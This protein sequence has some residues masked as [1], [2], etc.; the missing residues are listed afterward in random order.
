M[1]NTPEMKDDR[2]M[3]VPIMASA[4]GVIEGGTLAGA[5]PGRDA[6][7]AQ[8]SDA[9]LIRDP[10]FSQIRKLGTGSAVHYFAALVLQRARDTRAVYAD[11][12]SAPSIMSTV[13]F[14]P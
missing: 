4:A 9:S 2:T 8:R 10:G 1:P 12:A 11:R 13:F 3:V 5:C 6:A 14:R 7:Q